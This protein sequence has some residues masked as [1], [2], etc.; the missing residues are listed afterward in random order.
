MEK[1]KII[2]NKE[3]NSKPKFEDIPCGNLFLDENEL[4]YKLYDKVYQDDISYNTICLTN[5]YLYDFAP[6]SEVTPIK[7]INVSY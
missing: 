2:I 4:Y 3:N 5:G 7:E 1:T 6:H